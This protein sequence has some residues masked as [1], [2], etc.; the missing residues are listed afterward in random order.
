MV[1]YIEQIGA[2][3]VEVLKYGVLTD[4]YR[5]PNPAA[6]AADTNG[7]APDEVGIVIYTPRTP[8]DHFPVRTTV[9]LP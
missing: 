1:H 7:T 6:E 2:I 5:T 4:T 3:T 8:S 9:T